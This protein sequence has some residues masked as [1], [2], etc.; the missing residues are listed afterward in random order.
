MSLTETFN[1]VGDQTNENV[2]L[3]DNKILLD[4]CCQLSDVLSFG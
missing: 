4:T 2:V 1:G 3:I